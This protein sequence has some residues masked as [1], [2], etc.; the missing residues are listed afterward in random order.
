MVGTQKGG[1]KAVDNVFDQYHT[2]SLDWNSSRLKFY[3]D[4]SLIF[5]YYKE[6]NAGYDSWPFD[7]EF[8]IIINTAIGGN[9][10]IL[11]NIYLK[12]FILID[13]N[14]IHINYYK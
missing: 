2:Y 7:Q 4:D 14:L 10:V 11:K 3:I 8:N 6:A 5:A 12:K 13:S 1:S 9:W